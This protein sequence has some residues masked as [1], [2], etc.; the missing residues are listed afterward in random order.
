MPSHIRLRCPA[1]W[2]SSRSRS[3]GRGSRCWTCRG[4]DS[5]LS[6]VAGDAGGSGEFDVCLLD[7][8]QYQRLIVADDSERTTV[9]QWGLGVSSAAEV[10]FCVKWRCVEGSES[11]IY[12][13]LTS[14]RWYGRREG[15]S[16]CAMSLVWWCSR[17]GLELSGQCGEGVGGVCGGGAREF[18]TQR[19]CVQTPED[20]SVSL[21]QLRTSAKPYSPESRKT[22]FDK[23]LASKATGKQPRRSSS[24]QNG[25]TEATA[26]I[27]Q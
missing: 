18:A 19:F 24:R 27:N 6:R 22:P 14:K 26:V 21:F 7:V 9:K 20:E 15:V 2:P 8:E 25:T 16:D 1:R 13:R 10:L 17:A 5:I 23:H 3:P 4:K 12:E 11:L